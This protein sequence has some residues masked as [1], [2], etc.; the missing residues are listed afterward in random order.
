[1]KNKFKIKLLLLFIFIVI[2]LGLSI[3]LIQMYPFSE[4]VTNDAREKT[5]DYN[6]TFTIQREELNNDETYL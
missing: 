2:C 1:M 3:F 5:Y 4:G 6:S